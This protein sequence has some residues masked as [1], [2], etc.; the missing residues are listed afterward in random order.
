MAAATPQ[1]L[2]TD[3]EALAHRT[4]ADRRPVADH[5]HIG[6]RHP[7]T[8]AAAAGMEEGL[9]EADTPA[10]V[11]AVVIRPAEAVLQVVDTAV[12]IADPSNSPHEENAAPIGAAFSIPAKA[13]LFLHP[14]FSREPP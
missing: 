14:F 12:D 11:A 7:L 4:V 8:T 10:A 6:P 13:S 1:G 5:R 9:P 2:L 3:R